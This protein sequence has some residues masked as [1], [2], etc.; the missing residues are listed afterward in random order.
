MGK[1][2]RVAVASVAL[3]STKL[4]R[5]LYKRRQREKLNLRAAASSIGISLSTL[6]RMETRPDPPTVGNLIKVAKWLGVEP[7]D[8]I[9]YKGGP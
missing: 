5:A 3:A 2:S 1:Q 7:G 9:S 4:A 6:F 8:L